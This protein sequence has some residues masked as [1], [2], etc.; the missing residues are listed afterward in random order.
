MLEGL[1]EAREIVSGQRWVWLLT[2]V[3]GLF[4]LVDI[5]EAPKKIFLFVS[6]V[7]IQH[8]KFFASLNVF[9]KFSFGRR[10]NAVLEVNHVK[11]VCPGALVAVNALR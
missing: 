2:L 6:T 5:A 3:E 1:L 10:V 9:L 11:D 4:E 8:F 7:I